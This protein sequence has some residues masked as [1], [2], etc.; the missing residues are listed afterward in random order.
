MV[1][2]S[3]RNTSSALIFSTPWFNVVAKTLEDQQ[4]PYYSLELPDYVSVIAITDKN[5]VLLVRQYRPAVD[6]YT[7]ELPAGHVDAGET[8]A[9]SAE[10]ELLE[11]TGYQE[12][13]LEL[14]VRL[15]PHTGT[16]SN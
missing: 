13:H 15:L 2:T 5:H 8:P 1:D 11:E 9:E 12:N 6:S 16:L 7:L 14:L 4:E 3:A 10:R